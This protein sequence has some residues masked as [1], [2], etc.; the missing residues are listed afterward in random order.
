MGFDSIYGLNCLEEVGSGYQFSLQPRRAGRFLQ[1]V[2]LEPRQALHING[3]CC[4]AGPASLAAIVLRENRSAERQSGE[5]MAMIPG[6]CS[7]RLGQ[8]SQGETL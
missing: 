6:S 4:S 8:Q 3:V 2:S 5:A 7:S 1:L